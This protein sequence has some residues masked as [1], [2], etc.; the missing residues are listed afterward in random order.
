MEELY[1]YQLFSNILAQSFVIEGRFFVA[2]GYGNDLNTSNMDDIIKD[3]L[4]SIKSTKKYPLAILMPPV[5]VVEFKTSDWSTYSLE[6]YFLAATRNRI[7]NPLLNI[8]EHPIMYDWADMRRCAGDFRTAFNALVQIKKL[9]D[10]IR[11]SSR[12]ADVY[13]RISLSNNDKTSGVKLNFEVELFAP[14][15]LQDYNPSTL[16]DIVVP[17]QPIHPIHKM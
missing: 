14:C 3:A 8:N 16:K 15:V 4:G 5:E 12:S 17:T 1:I 9:S 13:K 10:S 6:M 11:S 2:E 7:T